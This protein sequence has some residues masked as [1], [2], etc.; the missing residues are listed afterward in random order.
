LPSIEDNY[1]IDYLGQSA[2]SASVCPD[3]RYR[4]AGMHVQVGVGEGNDSSIPFDDIS[5]GK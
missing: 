4:F 2:L 1:S 5:G 3:Q